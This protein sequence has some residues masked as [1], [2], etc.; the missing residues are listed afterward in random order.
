MTQAINKPTLWQRIQRQWKNNP[1]FSTA[2][3]LVLMIILQTC[4]RVSVLS[5]EKVVSV[6]P[7]T[8]PMPRRALAAS[9]V[10]LSVRSEKPAA[11]SAAAAGMVLICRQRQTTYQELEN[12]VESVRGVGSNL[13]GVIITDMKDEDRTYGKYDRYRYYKAYDYSYTNNETK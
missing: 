9:A 1:L 12:A 2:L 13:L 7:L 4:A 5:G 10:S 6:V 11:E 8:T 3:V